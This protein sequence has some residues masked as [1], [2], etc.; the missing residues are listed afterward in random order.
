MKLLSIMIRKNSR[1]FTLVELLVVIGIIAVLIGILLPSLSK[2]RFSAQRVQCES[3]L[4]QLGLAAMVYGTLNKNQIGQFRGPGPNS[5]YVDSAYRGPIDQSI[6]TDNWNSS[7]PPAPKQLRQIGPGPVYSNNQ[8]GPAVYFRAG[9]VKSS[10]ILYCPVDRFRQPNFN[11]LLLYYTDNFDQWTMTQGFIEMQNGYPLIV[12]S[13]D[14]NPLQLAT[15][16]KNAPL[17]AFY[18]ASYY[19]GTFPFQS[20]APSQ[21]PL[22]CDVL[23]SDTLDLGTGA[24]QTV[25]GQSHP[26][27]WNVLK[28]D[29]SVQAGHSP[30]VL[31]RQATHNVLGAYAA[32]GN[33]TWGEYETEL[34]M[35]CD[36]L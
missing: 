11:S 34:E 27:F 7:W 12:S 1:A 5:A 35:I 17:H 30:A 20:Y 14:W 36:G 9:I 13:Y 28:L 29:G 16:T 26:P 8:E 31:V 32:S 3:N 23:Q 10:A 24:N 25:D 33:G 4:R 18:A 2:A 21:L 22:A 6:Q 15:F 19:G